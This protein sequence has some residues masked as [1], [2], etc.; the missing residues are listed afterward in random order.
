[1]AKPHYNSPSHCSSAFIQRLPDGTQRRV[2]AISCKNYEGL[3]DLTK[4]LE[5]QVRS[6]YARPP[7]FLNEA[8]QRLLTRPTDVLL[9]QF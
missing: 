6:L 1:V 8:S 9:L 2:I 4:A 3:E 7:F 5:S